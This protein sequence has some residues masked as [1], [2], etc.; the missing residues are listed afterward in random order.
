MRAFAL[1]AI[2]EQPGDYAWV[3]T[4]DFLSAFAP[5]RLDYF[6][7]ETAL[8]VELLVLHRLRADRVDRAGVRRARR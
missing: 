3:V 7:Y 1:A 5:L 6:E 2:R 8:Q 4:R